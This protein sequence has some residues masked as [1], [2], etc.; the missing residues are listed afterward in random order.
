[1]GGSVQITCFVYESCTVALH[2]TL[3]HETFVVHLQL[4]SNNHA[5]VKKRFRFNLRQWAHE[6]THLRKLS[7]RG[8]QL[9]ILHQH[10]LDQRLTG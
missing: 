3:N 6:A 4:I 9:R 7:Q 2:S 1:M 5:V 10:H 8:H